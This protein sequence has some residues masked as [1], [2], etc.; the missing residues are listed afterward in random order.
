MAGLTAA[1]IGGALMP[2]FT[3]FLGELVNALGDPTQDLTA[4]VNK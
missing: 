2:V 1:A 4:E 3:I